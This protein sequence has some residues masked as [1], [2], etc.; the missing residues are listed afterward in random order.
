MTKTFLKVKRF[1]ENF[2]SLKRSE[3]YLRGINKIPDKLQDVI[4]I[5]VKYY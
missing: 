3:F 4:N 2:L 1:V 5:T